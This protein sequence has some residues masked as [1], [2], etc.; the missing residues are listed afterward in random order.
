MQAEAIRL[1]KHLALRYRATG[2]ELRFEILNEPVAPDAD[3]VTR[4]YARVL[5]AIREVSPERKVLVC[6]NRWGQFDTVE[7]L[8]PLL[9]DPNVVVAVHYYEPH[10]F[11]HQQASWV[12]WKH[13]NPPKIL[14]PGTVPDLKPYVS[15]DHY[16]YRKGGMVLTIEA[17]QEE[18]Q[19]LAEWA[20]RKNVELHLGEFG[21]YEPADSA[22]RERWYRTV[23]DACQKHNLGWA[24]WDYKGGFAVRDANT[25]QPTLVQKVIDDYLK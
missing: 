12:G 20:A 15:Q 6:S 5:A 8:A 22:S 4:F 14:F 9:S 11:T 23:L 17:V 19:R 13:P 3:S 1:W 7:A 16:G 24:V 18:F 21:V 10:I 25:G 2:P